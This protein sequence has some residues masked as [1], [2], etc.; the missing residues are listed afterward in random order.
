M[1]RQTQRDR[2]K[3]KSELAHK[4]DQW[5]LMTDHELMMEAK[6]RFPALTGEPN[7]GQLLKFLVMDH[8]DKID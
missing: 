3:I 6:Q 1:K 7:R 8:L 4:F 5:N 2:Q